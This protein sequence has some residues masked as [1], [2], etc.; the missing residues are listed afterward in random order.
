MVYGIK[1]DIKMNAICDGVDRHDSKRNSFIRTVERTRNKYRVEVLRRKLAQ[2]IQDSIN[3]EDLL[4]VE[5][6]LSKEESA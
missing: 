4:V 1:N 2:G 3:G 6:E 5:K